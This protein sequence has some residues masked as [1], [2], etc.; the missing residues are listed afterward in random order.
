M[1]ASINNPTILPLIESKEQLKIVYL[2]KINSIMLNLHF[3]SIKQATF[4]IKQCL[5]LN[6]KPFLFKNWTKK[7]LQK[8]CHLT[9]IKKIEFVCPIE[10]KKI[11]QQFNIEYNPFIKNISEL[12][13][14]KNY[15]TIFLS[16]ICNLDDIKNLFNKNLKTSILIHGKYCA[17]LDPKTTSCKIN[18]HAPCT[19]FG[20]MHLVKTI[21]QAKYWVINGI[22]QPITKF[23]YWLLIYLTW[24]DK[25]KKEAE[26]LTPKLL[27][28]GASFK[29]SSY[30]FLPQNPKPLFLN[31]KQRLEPNYLGQV[32]GTSKQRYLCPR[33][34]LYPKDSIIIYPNNLK[35]I[36]F[37]IPK[38]IPPRG[39]LNLPS[40]IPLKSA[41]YLLETYPLE[42][43][44]ALQKCKI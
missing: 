43:Q 11:F 7:D 37:S 8:I 30:F 29:P 34:P 15:K 19:D 4:I 31:L 14:F 22:G 12:I 27:Q 16:P 1:C 6:I 17:F 39:R 36:F 21:R 40:N 26:K 25:S 44:K 18:L 9:N 13:Y 10:Y 32:K 28:L 35:P 23:Y 41:A 42:L 33:Q 20:L 2:L 38:Y 3:L 5:Q 24:R